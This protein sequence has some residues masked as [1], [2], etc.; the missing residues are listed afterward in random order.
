VYLGRSKVHVLASAI[1]HMGLGQEGLLD[2]LQRS[3]ERVSGSISSWM[4]Q[5]R[6]V[7][8]I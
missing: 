5:L 6:R 2:L 4:F 1:A 7:W 3:L 8:L